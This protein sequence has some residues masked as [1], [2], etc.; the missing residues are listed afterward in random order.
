MSKGGTQVPPLVLPL[1][2]QLTSTNEKSQR[3]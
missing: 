1:Y 2:S 3:S